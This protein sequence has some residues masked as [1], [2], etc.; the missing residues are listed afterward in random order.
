MIFSSTAFDPVFLK[1]ALAGL[2]ATCCV[3]I[4]FMIG[5]NPRPRRFIHGNRETLILQHKLR[6]LYLIVH[7]TPLWIINSM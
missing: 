4:T 1:T 6:Y 7:I 5:F 2:T 3:N